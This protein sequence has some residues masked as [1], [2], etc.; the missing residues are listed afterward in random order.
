MAILCEHVASLYQHVAILCEHVA[1]LCEHTV[2]LCEHAAILCEPVATLCKRVA[3]LCERVAILCEHVATLCERVAILCE[4]VAI[5][6][7][8]VAILCERVAI[9]CKHVVILCEP[10]VS[11][12]ILLHYLSAADIE[13]SFPASVDTQDVIAIPPPDLDS[14]ETEEVPGFASWSTF[15]SAMPRIPRPSGDG[16]SPWTRIQSCPMLAAALQLELLSNVV[17]PAALPQLTEHGS[18]R[19]SAGA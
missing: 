17:P 2:I 16:P 19:G 11:L 13:G 3:I 18:R 8:H 6:C 1:I 7:E 9:L 4:R 10:V 5:L 14:D 12:A 15:M